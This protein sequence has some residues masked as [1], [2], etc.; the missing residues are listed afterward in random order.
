S[1]AGG[2]PHDVIAHPY[3]LAYFDGVW[4][5]VARDT[6]DG[7]IKKYA[8]DKISGVKKLKEAVKDMPGDLDETLAASVNI[9]FTPERTTEV[10]IEVDD[11]WAHYFERR[12]ILPLQEIVE[13]RDD[14]SL[15]V[16]FLACSDEEIAMCLKPWLPHVRIVEP[17]GVRQA[18]LDE[19]REWVLW[20]ESAGN[21]QG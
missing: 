9:W 21:H 15:L 2:S 18:L 4:Y 5:L 16:R 14:G 8:L 10:L 20:Q 7:V 13:R 3:R 11:Q 1:Y 12:G 6:K 17:E 19:F